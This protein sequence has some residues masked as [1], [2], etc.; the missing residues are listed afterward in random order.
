MAQSGLDSIRFAQSRTL[1]CALLSDNAIR[2]ESVSARLGLPGNP[3]VTVRLLLPGMRRQCLQE[4]SISGADEEPG[5]IS[6]HSC[7]DELGGSR[8]TVPFGPGTARR[9]ERLRRCG[10]STEREPAS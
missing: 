4:D 2:I 5:V 1:A 10:F 7:L 9:V 3:R 6:L 8:G